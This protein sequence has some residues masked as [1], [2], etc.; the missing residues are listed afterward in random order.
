MNLAADA[1]LADRQRLRRAAKAASLGDGEEIRELS[2]LDLGDH[3]VLPY[4]RRSFE[5]HEVSL[6]PSHPS[7]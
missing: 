5:G 1:R 2:G 7:R 3:L 6:G 4:V